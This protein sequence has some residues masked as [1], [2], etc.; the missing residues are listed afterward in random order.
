MQ[1]ID[2]RPVT[3]EDGFIKDI[4]CSEFGLC[5][6]EQSLHYM[7]QYKVHR[8][9]KLKLIKDDFNT[10]SF[11]WQKGDARK[12]LESLAEEIRY[13]IICHLMEDYVNDKFSAK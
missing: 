2:S 8:E 11:E 13:C 1:S 6:I 12:Y 7:D 10:L 9:E 3:T 5:T 4:L